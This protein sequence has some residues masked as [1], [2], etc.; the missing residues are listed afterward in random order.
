[1]ALAV[2]INNYSTSPLTGCIND[3][4]SIA[5]IIESNGDGSPN[6][7][8]KLVTDISSK[9]ELKGL[10][11]DLLNGDSE[12][13]LFYFSGHGYIDAV[14]GYIVTPDY[15]AY[16]LG[17]SMDEILKIA[18]D[19]KARIPIIIL[20]CCHSGAFGSPKINGG[21]TAQ[22]VEGVSILTASKDHESSLEINGHGV[23]TNLLLDALRGGAADLRGH[24]T[25]GGVYAYIDQALGPW[26][27]RPVFSSIIKSLAWPGAAITMVI[28]LKQP[29]VKIL[30]NLNK[31]TYNNLEMDF[32]NKLEEIETTLEDKQLPENYNQVNNI[33]KEIL[34]VAKISPAASVTMSWSMVKRK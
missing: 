2:G 27:Q 9:S 31:V 19:S 16:D 6:F 24:I 13:S 11:V 8:V 3:A 32:N 23:F 29:I 10:I 21:V 5:S 20:D 22:I 18:N 33:D 4:Y 7:D 17:V 1:M 14:G 28:L 30:S 12:T 26:D 15:Q 25:P 34:T